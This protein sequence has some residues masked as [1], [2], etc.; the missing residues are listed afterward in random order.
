MAAADGGHTSDEHSGEESDD[1]LT[2]HHDSFVQ[3]DTK[4]LKSFR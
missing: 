3:Q 1:P 4:Y 2:P